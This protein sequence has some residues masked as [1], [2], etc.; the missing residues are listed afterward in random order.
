MSHSI[1]SNNS[2]VPPPGSSHNIKQQRRMTSPAL[3]LNLPVYGHPS[4]WRPPSP[5]RNGF[6]QSEDGEDDDGDE[7]DEDGAWG[8]RPISPASSV[9]Q[10]AANFAERVGKLVSPQS[11]K[12]GLPTDAELE[13]QA[14]RERDRSRREAERILTQEAEERRLVEDKV[15][16]MMQNGRGSPQSLPTPVR[17]QTM[18]APGTSPSNS[19]K[20]NP[21]WWTAAKNRLTP[22]KDKEPLTPAQQVIHETKAR[23]KTEKKNGKGKEKEWPASSQSKY[24]DPAFL[25]LAPPTGPPRRP[26]PSSPSSPTPSRPINAAAP[27]ILTPSPMRPTE[28]DASSP[29]REPLPLYAQFN[30]QGTL[31]VPGTLLTIAKRFEK[32]EKWTVGHVRALEERMSDVERWLVDKEQ[33]KEKAESI[34]PGTQASTVVG[35]IREEVAELQGRVGELGREMAK[36]ATAPTNLSSGP[37]RQAAAISE[38]PPT[39]SEI[40]IHSHSASLASEYVPAAP[41]TPRTSTVR[42]STSP[43][44][45][46]AGQS[47]SG[48]TRL[49]YPTG[50]YATPPD[51]VALSQ[52]FFSPASS[53]PSS[54]TSAT[55]PLSISGLPNI[56][57]TPPTRASGLP[58]SLATSPPSRVKSPPNTS[59]LPPPKA[60]SPRPSSISP[61]PRKRYTVALG[62][63][64]TDPNERDQSSSISTAVFSSSPAATDDDEDDEFHDET[65][66]KSAARL[67]GGR[68]SATPSPTPQSS[69]RAR[70][71]SMYGP[72]APRLPST[73]AST[74]T[75]PLRPRVRSRS[76]VGLGI[77]DSGTGKFV[78]PLLVRRQELK[79]LTPKIVRADGK[80][81]VPV[82]QLVAFF[83]G[84]R[85]LQGEDER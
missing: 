8:R 84:E 16:A 26:A 32:L 17:A 48:R 75:T 76:T 22:T 68:N 79:D 72:S 69:S 25:N 6:S 61:T 36:L 11:A 44:L 85:R 56:T 24:T 37:A 71:H 60:A 33:E 2:L 9:S 52:G 83:D 45:A 21:S 31:D 43:P 30:A 58:S 62:G 13:A 14:E 67:A 4:P 49:P 29:S 81:K 41:V 82:G 27:P 35:E 15:F 80:K 70:P 1:V 57:S 64:I 20:E 12:S 47:A 34:H 7:D 65:I 77:T 18:P 53:P 63:P 78:D 39:T 54:L 51:T 5:L 40:A 46:S 38:A 3:P 74:T 59:S 10:F 19:T 66:G 55:R 28:G 42:D 23:E 50:D 73:A